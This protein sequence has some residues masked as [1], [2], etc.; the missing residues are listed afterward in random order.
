[1]RGKGLNMFKAVLALATVMVATGGFAIF[2]GMGMILNER[3]WTQVIGG[4]VVLSTGLL[5]LSLAALL[6]H[7]RTLFVTG[8]QVAGPGL[9]PEQPVRPADPV[10]ADPSDHGHP[11]AHDAGIPH[12]ASHYETSQ[13]EAIHQEASRLDLP[14]A[15]VAHADHVAAPEPIAAFAETFERDYP[16]SVS[17]FRPARHHDRPQERSAHDL[18]SDLVPPPV[19]MPVAKPDEWSQAAPLRQ[20]NPPLQPSLLDSLTQAAPYHARYEPVRPT[21][22]PAD[23][24]ERE[25]V[26]SYTAGGVGYFMYSDQTIEAEMAIGRYR[27]ASMDELRHFVETNEGGVKVGESTQI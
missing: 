8:A 3:G 12:A 20:D 17:A 21:M 25:L 15:A 22:P 23:T 4:S 26:A 1:M 16:V 9:A 5:I 6:A 10:F 24:I 13:Q 19:P 27:F 18:L 11:Q 14:P 7:A 2:N